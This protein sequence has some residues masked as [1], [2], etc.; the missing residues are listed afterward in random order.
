MSGPRRRSVSDSGAAAPAAL[1]ASASLPAAPASR[2]AGPPTRET[3]LIR[4]NGAQFLKR[5]VGNQRYPDYIVRVP[6]QPDQVFPFEQYAQAGR[7]FIAVAYP[8]EAR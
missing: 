7:A 4:G 8:K 5:R 1:P 6:G 2:D 3:V